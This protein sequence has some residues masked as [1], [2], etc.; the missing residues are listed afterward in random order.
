MFRSVLPDSTHRALAAL[1]PIELI[2]KSYLAGGSAL[3]LQLGHRESLDLD[4]FTQEPFEPTIAVQAF[5]KALPSFRLTQTAWGTI[6]GEIDRV[7]FSLFYYQ[8]PL[9]NPTTEF[10]RIRLA[11]QKDIAAMKLS[12]I[13][14]R[15]LKRDFIDLFVLLEHFSLPQMFDFY[16][17]KFRNRDDLLPHLLKALVYFDDAE[18]DVGPKLFAPI[19]WD[20]VKRTITDAVLQYRKNLLP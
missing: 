14:D 15:G 18:R 2:T 8:Y 12:A 9:I 6:L 13:A 4:F 20:E 5:Q 16:D 7:K 11:S 10:E 1:A 17:R 3:A 19:E